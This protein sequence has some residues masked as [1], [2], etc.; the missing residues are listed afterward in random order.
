M[1]RQADSV[2]PLDIKGEIHCTVTRSKMT[3]QLDTL[4]VDQ[5]DVDVLAGNPFMVMNDVATR[6]AKKQ[7]VL[8]GLDIVYYG[9]Q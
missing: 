1:A 5:L 4:V 3:F 7:I 2:T 6:P 8:R 9:P